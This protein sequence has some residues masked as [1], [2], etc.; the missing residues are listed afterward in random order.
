MFGDY[1]LILIILSSLVS[2]VLIYMFLKF[3][4]PLARLSLSVV[5]GGAIGNLIDRIRFFEVIDFIDFYFWSY[6]FPVINVADIMVTCGTV[7]LVIFVIFYYKE[8][9]GHA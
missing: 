9:K 7:L 3:S 6:N 4:H 1:T 2:L 8:D 5:L